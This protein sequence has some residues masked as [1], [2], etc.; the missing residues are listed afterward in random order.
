MKVSSE[1]RQ[2]LIE[3][4]IASK[5]APKTFLATS[6]VSPST[7][8]NAS[9]HSE[10]MSLDWGSAQPYVTIVITAGVTFAFTSV[11][12][13]LVTKSRENREDE[14]AERVRI[15]EESQAV[16]TQREWA[17]Q[18]WWSRKYDAYAQVLEALW[19]RLDDSRST[20]DSIYASRYGSPSTLPPSAKPGR[21]DWVDDRKVIRRLTDFGGF[22]IAEDAIAALRSYELTVRRLTSESE[23]RNTEE[24]FEDD[25]E[26]MEKCLNEVLA[27]ALV[28]LNL[29]DR[30]P[31]L[32]A[33][34][35]HFAP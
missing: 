34:S 27:A 10:E 22:L 14:L 7:T 5:A 32:G 24:L 11:R 21:S 1:D 26:A 16:R 35:G 33:T 4:S 9:C 28:D 6:E 2:L 15:S 30:N 12:D 13:H 25:I 8:V 29:R 31:G 19:R 20:L 23:C 18:Q 17:Q 3:A